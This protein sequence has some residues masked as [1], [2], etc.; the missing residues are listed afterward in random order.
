M[1][2]LEKIK[3]QKLLILIL[4][5]TFLLRLFYLN[6]PKAYVFDEVYHA[7][8]A[9]EFV[10]GNKEGWEWWNTP[11]S[12]VAYEWT[13]PPLAKEIMAFSMII[14]NNQ[15]SWA[16]RFPGVILGVLSVYLIF[17]LAI[18]LFNNQNIALISAFLFSIDGLNFVQSRTGMNDTYLV[19]FILASLLFFLNKKYFISSLFFSLAFASKWSAVY[20]LPLYFSI[21]L[22]YIFPF[23]FSSYKLLD[24]I[25]Y[26][27]KKGLYFMLIPPLIYLLVY[28][29]FFTLG[30]T[31][32]QFTQLQQQ[33]WWYH[34]GLKA[35]HDYSSAWWSWP[36][37]L[38]PVWYFV[39]YQGN[40]IANIFASG[41]P[42]L[43]WLGTV[44]ILLTL[45]E[46]IK[47]RSQKL[48]LILLG[49]FAF[50]LPWAL[51]PRIMFLY[52]YAPS[53]PFLCLILGY[54]LGNGLKEKRDHKI[55]YLL[56]ITC[57]ISFIFI[58]PYLV[59][60]PIPK[61]FVRLFFMTNIT[62]D[63]FN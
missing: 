56:I 29:P 42:V 52:H 9:K 17:L 25:L 6:Y 2:L 31:F 61:Y 3:Y 8:T 58:Y 20:L 13:H 1:N 23:K 22:F 7:F 24:K 19:T 38:Y 28:L 15:D 40:N 33:M 37:N 49:F 46:F 5:I 59:G 14:F 44:S 48:G 21:S 4:L 26:A 63:P 12:G 41:N 18:K 34:T 43:F 51:S 55:V 60:L 53:I 27:L 54:Q 35:S 11:P 47:K 57:I 10:K 16:W 32:N 36:L 62:R 30:H 50:F 45:W 39:D